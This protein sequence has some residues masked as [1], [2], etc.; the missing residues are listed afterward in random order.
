MFVEIDESLTVERTGCGDR[1]GS[2]FVS[3]VVMMVF[4]GN[5]TFESRLGMGGGET[6]SSSIGI[7]SSLEFL[8]LFL[9]LISNTKRIKS[10]KNPPPPAA[11]A[12]GATDDDEADSLLTSLLLLLLLLGIQLPLLNED[13]LAQDVQVEEIPFEQATLV[14]LDLA[15]QVEQEPLFK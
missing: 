1:L 11:P 10:N 4:G 2:S 9:F 13:P 12:I 15:K 6:L 5:G 7:A 3:D 8:F 14:Q